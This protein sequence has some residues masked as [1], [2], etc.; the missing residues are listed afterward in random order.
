MRK[1]HI[2]PETKSQVKK[3][4]DKRNKEPSS[5]ISVEK[6]V[7]TIIFAADRRLK[8]V[9]FPLKVYMAIFLRPFLPDLI[10]E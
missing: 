6:C 8:K 2:Q 9:Y 5:S 10:D 3:N 1:H 7:E 4:S